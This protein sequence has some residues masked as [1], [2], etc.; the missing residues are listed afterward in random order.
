MHLGRA[1]I[2][3]GLLGP[4]V[5]L[6]GPLEFRQL[7]SLADVMDSAI[8]HQLPDALGQG[9]AAQLG[10]GRGYRTVLRPHVERRRRSGLVLG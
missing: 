3:F 4:V 9:T 2:T 5:F 6:P 1:E 8:R 10:L 7:L